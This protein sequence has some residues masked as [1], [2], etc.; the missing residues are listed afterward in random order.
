[1]PIIFTMNTLLEREITISISDLKP[2][3]LGRPL[4]VVSKKMQPNIAKNATKT[5]FIRIVK[6]GIK[7]L[8]VANLITWSHCIDLY[9]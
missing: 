9:Q 2:N 1:M 3:V 8:N 5:P 4:A 7:F 6:E